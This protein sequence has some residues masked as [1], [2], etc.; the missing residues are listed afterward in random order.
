MWLDFLTQVKYRLSENEYRYAYDLTES[1]LRKKQVLYDTIIATLIKQSI[2]TIE[3]FHDQIYK[4]LNREGVL[5]EP[6]TADAVLRLFKVQYLK[7]SST[8][9]HIV[10][11]HKDLLTA[12]ILVHA[13]DAVPVPMTIYDILSKAFTVSTNKLE[14]GRLFNYRTMR[15]TYRHEYA[16]KALYAS[17]PFDFSDF[18]FHSEEDRITYSEL[19]GVPGKL[20]KVA[21]K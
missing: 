12:I 15:Y 18:F 11:N 17:Y 3:Y 19:L 16:H 5:Q 9:L 21:R 10:K 2:V 1:F 14:P 7:H 4:L 20:T 8:F 13:G 6:L